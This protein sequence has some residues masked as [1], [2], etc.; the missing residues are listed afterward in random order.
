M[1]LWIPLGFGVFHNARVEHCDLPGYIHT[2][3]KS[4]VNSAPDSTHST[5]EMWPT[6]QKATETHSWHLSGRANGGYILI[7]FYLEQVLRTVSMLSPVLVGQGHEG[8]CG[9]DL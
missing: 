7:R 4:C 2:G 1:A 3:K 8:A 5:R 9:T 6:P